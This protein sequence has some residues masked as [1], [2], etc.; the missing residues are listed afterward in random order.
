MAVGKKSSGGRP[1]LDLWDHFH[2]SGKSANKA[3]NKAYCLYELDAIKAQL[4]EEDTKAVRAGDLE[5]PRSSEVLHLDACD[6]MCHTTSKKSTLRN[7]LISCNAVPE[8]VKAKF[9]AQ[10]QAEAGGAASDDDTPTTVT[11]STSSS[12]SAPAKR[13]ATDAPASGPPPTKKRQQQQARFEV[14]KGPSV[15]WSRDRQLAFERQL[16]RAWVSV[17]IA[18]EGIDDH[19][20]RTIFTDFFPWVGVPHRTKLSTTC[21]QREKANQEVSMRDTVTGSYSTLQYDGW[22]HSRKHL[23]VFMFTADVKTFLLHA[24][25][26]S[27]KRKTAAN[28]FP[29]IEDESVYLEK[30]G[31]VLIGLCSDAAGEPRKARLMTV[32]KHKHLLQA[33][34]WAHQIQL[35]FGD[36]LKSDSALKDLFEQ[37]ESVVKWFL[38]HSWPL[39]QLFAEQETMRCTALA[40]IKAVITRWTAHYCSAVRLLDVS[41][42]MRSLVIKKEKELVESVGKKRETQ[43]VARKVMRIV[44]DEAFWT[45]VARAKRDLEPLAVAARVAQ[46]AYIRCDHILL[47]LGRIY[48]L[49]SDMIDKDS[50]GSASSRDAHYLHGV[51]DSIKKRWSKA[52]QDLFVLCLFLNPRICSQLFDAANLSLSRII[53]SA[54]RMYCKVFKED[55]APAALTLEI[56]R[57]KDYQREFSRA[58]WAIDDLDKAQEEAGD[59]DA[60]LPWRVLDERSPLVRLARLVLSFNPTSASTERVLSDFGNQ[61][62]PH[63]NRLG[64]G[65]MRDA[66]FVKLG[67]RREHAQLGIGR[68]RLRTRFGLAPQKSDHDPSGRRM[69]DEEAALQTSAPRNDSDSESD[70]ETAT[71]TTALPGDESPDLQHF[72]GLAQTILDELD[73]HE[74][75]GYWD[76]DDLD[77]LNSNE[78]LKVGIDELFDYSLNAKWE[79][80]WLTAVKSVDEEL[81]FYE[82]LTQS[83][84]ADADLPLAPAYAAALKAA[85]KS[86][87][88]EPSAGEPKDTPIV[89]DDD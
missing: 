40:L 31:S 32:K 33:D 78:A 23:Q 65:K 66:A 67:I 54:K 89:I 86:A 12:S 10:K 61:R 42:A 44:K 19:E 62:T 21:L 26:V 7:H 81:E 82:L 72:S 50:A 36:L 29:L 43:D 45:G 8:A 55:T 59:H 52:D 75:D 17:G 37:V 11:A 15:S 60:L 6:K 76:E 18:W 34:C 20:F 35:I 27:S 41:K 49:Y 77:I 2:D 22:T 87:E 51:L 63:R 30:I 28:L 71:P 9:R 1:K 39:A 53:V 68:R 4:R 85:Q 47:I 88:P 58:Q 14:V 24:Y 79:D 25:D 56:I 84:Q 48:K 70:S 64:V 16:L 74:L 69:E 80:F 46:G 57:Y 83:Q 38:N 73:D 5:K 13:K 3:Y